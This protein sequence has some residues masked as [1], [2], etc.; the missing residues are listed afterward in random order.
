MTVEIRINQT[1]VYTCLYVLYLLKQ[2]YKFFPSEKIKKYSI[3]RPVIN[4]ISKYNQPIRGEDATSGIL[5]ET[6]R[7]Y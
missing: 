3:N 4:F 7:L 5:G 6:Q 1:R 2:D